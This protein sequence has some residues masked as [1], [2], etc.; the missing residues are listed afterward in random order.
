LNRGRNFWAEPD[1]SIPRFRYSL[2]PL[3]LIEKRAII[4]E[5]KLKWRIYC[6]VVFWAK[7]IAGRILPKYG[8]SAEIR[9]E[10]RNLFI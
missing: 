9:A 8:N 2:A 5:N 1:V 3:L 10:R 7:N 4:C 6:L